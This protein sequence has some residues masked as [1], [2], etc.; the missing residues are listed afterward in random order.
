M[1]SKG[2]EVFAL[3]SGHCRIG[4]NDMNKM[5]SPQGL[6]L[7]LIRNW[8]VPIGCGLFFLF[9]LKHIFFVGYVPSDSMEPAIKEGSFVFGLRIYGELQCG[10]I[11]IFTHEGRLL[12][13][14]ISGM[15]GDII[16]TAAGET[17]TVPDGCYFMLGDNSCKSN[18]SRY[19]ETPFVCRDNIIAKLPFHSK[20]LSNASHYAP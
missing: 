5:Q 8:A 14:R 10:D 19:W 3:A 11:V 2:A 18:D 1:G 12:I 16:H 17:L 15:Q 7:R 4:G 13:K 9:L 6:Y 20:Q